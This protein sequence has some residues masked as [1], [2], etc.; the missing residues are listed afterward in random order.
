LSLCNTL[1]DYN[2]DGH[3]VS[4]M[5][6]GVTTTYLL[7]TATPLTMVLAEQTGAAPAI[8]YLHGL[9]LTAQSDGVTTEYFAYDGLGSVRQVADAIGSPLL[10]QTFDP[11]GSLYARAGIA[12][13]A[14]GFTGEQ[15]DANGLL[16]L[17]ARYY[18]PSQG[19]FFQLDPSRLEVN[20]YQYASGSPINRVD[21][22]G[23]L[24]CLAPTNATEVLLCTSWDAFN[25]NTEVIWQQGSETAVEVL[26]PV[27]ADTALPT[28]ILWLT[29]A[30]QLDQ[31]IHGAFIRT[32]AGCDLAAI[33]LA[34]GVTEPAHQMS[35]VF[36]GE[37]YVSYFSSPGYDVELE[38][39]RSIVAGVDTKS[40][41]GCDANSFTAWWFSM[42]VVAGSR[43]PDKDWYQYEQRVAR[44]GGLLGDY[45]RAT[46]PVDADGIEPAL[47]C[48]VDAK[49]TADPSTTQ[50]RADG[51]P[52]IVPFLRQEFESYRNAV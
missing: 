13:T 49:Y 26:A 38:R 52:W 12:E 10:T 3:R 36:S 9:D 24:D 41:E 46:G 16:Y 20:P 15:S 33:T 28:V 17:R 31:A 22:T 39:F 43:Q 18:A 6:D 37:E 14:W 48:F 25:A 35:A 5:V 2:G 40:E 50:F 34:H 51:P 11:Y 21:P 23:N 8:Y 30:H 7:D 1:L 44:Q 29:V 45:A 27:V 42:P 19:R 32:V 4:Q 47:C